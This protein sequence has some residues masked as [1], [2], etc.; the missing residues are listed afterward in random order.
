MEKYLTKLP[1][2]LKNKI[3]LYL[4]HPCSKMI[5]DSY[6]IVPNDC[7]FLD[8]LYNKYLEEFVGP[9]NP[10]RIY[11]TDCFTRDGKYL[12]GKVQNIM[13]IK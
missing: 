3:F 10:F 11:F 5:K 12:W 7:H 2:P 8:Y 4:E 13:I 6:T 9:Y 1:I